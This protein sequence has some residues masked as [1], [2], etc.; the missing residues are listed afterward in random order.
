MLCRSLCLRIEQGGAS[1]ATIFCPSLLSSLYERISPKK[2][3]LTVYSS[4]VVLNSQLLRTPFS[5]GNGGW[6]GIGHL[7]R[8]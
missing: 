6:Y 3:V 8:F 2:I 7:Y 4:Q 5:M 1:A